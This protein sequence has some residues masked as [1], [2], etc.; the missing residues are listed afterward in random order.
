MYQP[1]K[2]QD[3]YRKTFY[4]IAI[5]GLVSSFFLAIVTRGQLFLGSFIY[6]NTNTFM[7]YFN[8]V[9]D[10]ITRT[11]Y[12]NLVIYPPLANLVYL[13]FVHLSSVAAMSQVP[14]VIDAFQ[15]RTCQDYMLPFM[16]Y[17]M[18]TVL[19][20]WICCKSLKKGSEKERILFSFLMLFSLPL[21]YA[22]ERGNIIVVALIFTMMFF[23]WKDSPNKVLREIALISLAIAAGLKI[24]PAIFGFLVL[25]EKRYK[26][27]LRLLTYGVFLL[28]VPFV[29]FGGFD[30]IVIWLH[31]LI[32]T[33][34]EVAARYYSYK[35]NFSNTLEWITC[36]A[37]PSIITKIFIFL[38]LTIGVI[39]CFVLQE[40]WKRVLIATL[41]LIGL[42]AI[43]AV[44]AGIFMMIPL[45]YFLD[46]EK[47]K[48]RVNFIYLLLMTS[49]MVLIPFSGWHHLG[50]R[51]HYKAAIN[52]STAVE[53]T[54]ILMLT[55]MLLAEVVWLI[56]VK[57]RERLK[58][59]KC[60]AEK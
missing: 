55:L 20:V 40:E 43:S 47:R 26:E 35:L 45:I 30:H 27:T 36:G 23:L 59:R 22:F 5:V 10:V 58:K 42:P 46:H 31:N 6:D 41:L 32:N 1:L 21:L 33:S 51:M 15:M 9:R 53:S 38:T 57:F 17:F 49:T 4:L 28:F 56:F 37:I 7:D 54:A 3:L 24:Y 18:A 14:G 48:S 8:S 34:A 12:E 44:Y 25:R 16:F 13:G 39:G 52:L 19:G 50:D 11:P 2:N 29:F 60:R